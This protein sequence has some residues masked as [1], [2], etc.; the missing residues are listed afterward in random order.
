MDQSKHGRTVY[1]GQCSSRAHIHTHTWSFNG[2]SGW[3]LIVDVIKPLKGAK[4]KALADLFFALDR[5]SRY[6]LITNA[7]PLFCKRKSSKDQKHCE[8]LVC[9]IFFILI[10]LNRH[11]KKF[12]LNEKM[13]KTD[14]TVDGA[15]FGYFIPFSPS[16]LHKGRPRSSDFRAR[17][18]SV[19]HAGGLH[20][21]QKWS[22]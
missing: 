20:L 14:H 4:E 8:N 3:I 1:F 15:F 18:Q 11:E 6:K 22:P 2:K 10:W 13:K 21:I 7:P 12:I 19:E 17:P 9:S 5:L 16:E